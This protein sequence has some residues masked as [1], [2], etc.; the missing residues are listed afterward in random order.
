[1]KKTNQNNNLKKESCT[2][3]IWDDAQYIVVLIVESMKERSEIE[4][5]Q[6]V[7]EAEEERVEELATQM[8]RSYNKRRI[9]LQLVYRRTPK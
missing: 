4:G 8:L 3:C 9:T 7:R 6:R 2:K 1:M 5:T